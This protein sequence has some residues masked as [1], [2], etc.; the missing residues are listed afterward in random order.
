MAATGY[1]STTGDARK[2]SKAGDTMTGELTLPDSFP[3]TALAAASRGY[4]DA[5]AETKADATHAATHA[6]DGDDPV[7]VSI[8]QV[9]GLAEALAALLSTEGGTVNGTI[10][11]VNGQLLLVSG[12]T[13]I[14]RVG[15]GGSG[16]F[17][18]Y[19]LANGPDEADERWA[20]QMAPGSDDVLLVDSANG[21]QVLR[22]ASGVSARVGFLGAT[23]VVRQPV[24]GSWTDG[25]AGQ[26]LAAAL[27]A[28]GLITD[29]T[30]P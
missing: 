2:V 6:E 23:P 19:V 1:V 22:F 26:S 29:G 9:I 5:A 25:T 28:F 14:N 8:D 4:V 18:A 21:V 3:D 16:F 24:T 12:G 17:A 15:R 11:I 27:A 20:F 13:A 30:T 7:A 10:T